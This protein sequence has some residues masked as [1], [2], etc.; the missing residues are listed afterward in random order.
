MYIIRVDWF[1][2]SPSP[3]LSFFFSH[4]HSL[5]KRLS[6]SSI[7]SRKQNSER[8]Q[9]QRQSQGQQLHPSSSLVRHIYSL[10]SLP[11]SSFEIRFRRCLFSDRT[12][13]SPLCSVPVSLSVAL[14]FICARLSC[15]VEEGSTK[16]VAVNSVA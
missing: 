9:I 2:V 8:D 1:H 15:L 11:F 13:Q 3:T 7:L 4:S 10:R 6:S 14:R 5:S 16:A 12:L